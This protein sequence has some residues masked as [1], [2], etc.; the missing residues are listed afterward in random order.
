MVCEHEHVRAA[1]KAIQGPG[2]LVVAICEDCGSPFT[3]HPIDRGGTELRCELRIAL[4]VEAGRP[5]ACPEC[6]RLLP[7]EV[8]ETVTECGPVHTLTGADGRTRTV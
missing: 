2:L 6:E 4:D 1:V 7:I 3:I 8:G 5:T